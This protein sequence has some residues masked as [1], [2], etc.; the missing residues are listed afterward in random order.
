MNR[1]VV[2]MSNIIVLKREF[3]GK[4]PQGPPKTLVNKLSCA[5]VF[6]KIRISFLKEYQ[7]NGCI[8]GHLYLIE[9]L[10]LMAEINNGQLIFAPCEKWRKYPS[11][12]SSFPH[13]FSLPFLFASRSRCWERFSISKPFTTTWMT[14]DSV[15]QTFFYGSRSE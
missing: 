2:T 1:N 4:V 11:P 6:R 8:S 14:L 7:W 5:E 12:P 15:A 10:F 13:L 3:F 9:L